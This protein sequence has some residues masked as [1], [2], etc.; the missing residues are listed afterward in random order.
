M[1]KWM[2]AL[3]ALV[4]VLLATGCGSEENRIAGNWKIFIGDEAHAYLEI[5]PERLISTVGSEKPITADYTF[6]E[7]EGG[8]F[9]LD[10]FNPETRKNELLFEGY[11]EDKNTIKVV[12]TPSGPIENS[13]LIRVDVS[14]EKQKELNKTSSAPASE[15]P[16]KDEVRAGTKP[17]EAES[18][19][20]K[21]EEAEPKI[22]TEA[23]PKAAAESGLQSRYAAKAD[24][25]D[26]SIEEEAEKLFAHDTRPGFYGGYYED[27]DNLLQETWNEL[28]ATM[29]SEAFERLKAEQIE[30]IKK[31]EK[32]FNEFTDTVASE[33]AAGMDY[34]AFETKERTYYLIRN[35]MQ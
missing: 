24:Q 33:R 32:R 23:E 30:W 3:T 4:L 26:R 25:L 7:T 1:N 12:N 31:K 27:W 20:A 11:F 16:A 29:P 21:S 22:R 2:P 35:H 19:E 28:K 8:H 9:M 14:A 13:K 17:E 34:L 15:Q 10:V 6:T 5:G 18:M